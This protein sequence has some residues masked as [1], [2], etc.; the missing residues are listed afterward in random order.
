MAEKR[1]AG[2]NALI[3]GASSGIGR[4][5]AAALA[6]E[7]ANVALLGRRGQA[8]ATVAS[9]IENDG[10]TAR[11]VVADVTREEERQRAIAETISA[12]G[13]LDILVN[14]AGVAAR[15]PAEEMTL[16]DVEIGRA[17]V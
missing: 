17:H 9:A 13:A 11:T 12:L 2:K 6:R 4:A 7:G 16:A 1:F 5:T 3:T 15:G 10:G 14:A 8:L